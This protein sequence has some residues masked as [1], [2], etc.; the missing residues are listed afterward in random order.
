VVLHLKSIPILVLAVILA[1]LAAGASPAVADDLATKR[2]E[3][4]ALAA[5]ISALDSGLAASVADYAAAVQRQSD[6]EDSIRQSSHELEVLRYQLAVAQARLRERVTALY[7][8]EPSSMLEVFFANGSFTDLLT[9]LEYSRRVEAGDSSVVDEVEGLR[10]AAATRAARLASDLAESRVSTARLQERRDAVSKALGE[11]RSLLSGVRADI[12]TLATRYAAA[13]PEAPA[14]TPPSAGSDLQGDGAWWPS[15]QNAA[16]AN[17][18]S[19]VGLYR[20]MMAE[21]GGSATA[22]NGPY[23]GLFQYSRSTWGGS[24]NPWRA[25]GIFD[26]RAQIDATALAIRQGHGPGWWGSTYAWAFGGD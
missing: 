26:G 17:H 21:S 7:K 9:G 11:R 20:L 12:A 4:R 13:T 2:A 8:N 3:A 15:I 6:L 19:A 16:A 22:T 10:R 18:I 25:R 5:D 14:G 23:C 24:W 1:T